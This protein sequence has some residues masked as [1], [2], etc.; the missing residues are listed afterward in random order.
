M[1]GGTF[2]AERWRLG[3]RRD[4][5]ANQEKCGSVAVQLCAAWPCGGAALIADAGN[6]VPLA[7]VEST[8]C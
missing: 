8:G 3:A 2:L 4:D 6:E 7:G 5:A 1:G